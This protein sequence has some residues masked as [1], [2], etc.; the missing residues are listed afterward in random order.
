MHKLI[1]VLSSNISNGPTIIEQ[2]QGI[3]AHGFLAKKI[4]NNEKQQAFVNSVSTRRCFLPT[5][6]H[7]QQRNRQVCWNIKKNL[8]V[9]GEQTYDIRFPR[10]ALTDWDTQAHKLTPIK[11]HKTL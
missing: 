10:N 7:N 1:R 9:G 11:K 3:E 2:L 6:F 8:V 5:D 4:Y